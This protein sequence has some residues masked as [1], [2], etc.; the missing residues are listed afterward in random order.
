M[1]S[2]LRLRPSLRPRLKATRRPQNLLLSCSTV[3]RLEQQYLRV[4]LWS[5]VKR[6]L[7][8]PFA[9]GK[10]APLNWMYYWLCVSVIIKQNAQQCSWQRGLRWYWPRCC[11][12]WWGAAS[13][14]PSEAWWRIATQLRRAT[15]TLFLGLT[16]AQPNLIN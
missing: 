15:S 2:A 4:N 12:I 11:H 7:M 14:A 1:E 6:H 5:Q 8:Q 3:F 10:R 13:R 9:T 16:A